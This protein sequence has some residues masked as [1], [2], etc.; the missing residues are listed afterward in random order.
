MNMFVFNNEKNFAEAEK[1]FDLRVGGYN[2]P[3]TLNNDMK[4][5]HAFGDSSTSQH[6]WYGLSKSASDDHNSLPIDNTMNDVG[7]MKEPREAIR[8]HDEE[9]DVTNHSF[10]GSAHNM[11]IVDYGNGVHDNSIKQDDIILWQMPAPTRYGVQYT[12]WLNKE[13]VLPKSLIGSIRDYGVLQAHNIYTDKLMNLIAYSLGE[14][15]RTPMA[16]DYVQQARY[17]VSPMSSIYEQ[18]WSLNGIKK[19]NPKILVLFGYESAFDDHAINNYRHKI[20]EFLNENGIDYIEDTILEWA[21]NNGHK[22]I[23]ELHPDWIGYRAFTKEKLEPK[24][25]QLGWI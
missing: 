17:A 16:P 25:Q 14:G 20:V 13:D 5:I 23:D 15:K 11:Q 7:T 2:R 10:T 21:I 18:L 12:T 22:Q 9:Y 1:V 24:L 6:S 3:P 19:R 8:W 4:R